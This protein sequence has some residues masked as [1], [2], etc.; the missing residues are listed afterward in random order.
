M[1]RMK[2]DAS[3]PSVKPV[4]TNLEN[5][6]YFRFPQ[7]GN[8]ADLKNARFTAGAGPTPSPRPYPAAL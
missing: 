6:F 3:K 1:T 8:E 2:T 7:L 5:I 4:A